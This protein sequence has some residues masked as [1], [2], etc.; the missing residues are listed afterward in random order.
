MV[1]KIDLEQTR[2]MKKQQLNLIST[3]QIGNKND[4]VE[5]NKK[6]TEEIDCAGGS[7]RNPKGSI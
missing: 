4:F 5:V 3:K 6:W 2:V 1:V 7:R